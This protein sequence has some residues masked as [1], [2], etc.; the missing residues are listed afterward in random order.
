MK[1][2]ARLSCSDFPLAGSDAL[3]PYYVYGTAR[4]GPD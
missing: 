3:A 4:A 2:M 1:Q